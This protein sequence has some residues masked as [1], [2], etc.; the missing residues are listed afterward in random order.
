MAG[1]WK[2]RLKI[3]ENDNGTFFWECDIKIQLNFIRNI[4]SDGLK[5]IT[6]RKYIC[7]FKEAGFFP[8][9]INEK[10]NL[11]IARKI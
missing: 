3:F 1:N 4:M 10:N 7:K 9:K 6:I 5:G 11:H 8:Q 2:L